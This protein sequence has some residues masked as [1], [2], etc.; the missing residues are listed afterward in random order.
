M[1]RLDRVDVVEGRCE[2]DIL[3]GW[4]GGVVLWWYRVF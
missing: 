4:D 3:C 2:V 1:K